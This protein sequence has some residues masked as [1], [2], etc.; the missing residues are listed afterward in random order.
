MD[1]NGW[2]IWYWELT[3]DGFGVSTSDGSYSGWEKLDMDSDLVQVAERVTFAIE[4]SLLPAA[5]HEVD[6]PGSQPIAGARIDRIN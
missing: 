1:E 6:N 2:L 3:T 5:Q 4:H